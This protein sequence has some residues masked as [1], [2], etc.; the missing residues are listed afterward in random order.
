MEFSWDLLESTME[1]V[2]NVLGDTIRDIN[3]E[4][5]MA[6]QMVKSDCEIPMEVINDHLL[7]SNGLYNGYTSDES[8]YS[9]QN[10]ETLET[11]DNVAEDI[12]PQNRE[13]SNTWPRRRLGPRL[14]GI[15]SIKK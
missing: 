12:L 14:V 8:V 10:Y 5:E 4:Q 11:G 1:K 6:D 13:R 7:H 15:L 9:E 3:I 2:N